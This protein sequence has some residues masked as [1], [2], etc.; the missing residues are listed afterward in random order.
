MSASAY[1]ADL[2]TFTSGGHIAICV[3]S[4]HTCSEGAQDM[5]AIA[6]DHTGL[7]LEH[8]VT[9]SV[10]Y[11]LQG[12]VRVLLSRLKTKLNTTLQTKALLLNLT[13]YV[14]GGS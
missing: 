1:N 11:H 6:L 3:M 7:A 2:E 9:S 4:S 5:Q 14:N 10:V 13:H 8:I 12:T